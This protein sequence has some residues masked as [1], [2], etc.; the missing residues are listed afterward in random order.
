MNKMTEAQVV[1]RHDWV[2][3][4]VTTVAKKLRAWICPNGVS[5]NTVA[6]PEFFSYSGYG[7]EEA[8][9]Y[10]HIVRAKLF[11]DKV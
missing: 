9:M 1:N 5:I 8:I 3:W 10:Q 2:M 11:E 6:G 4:V 7:W